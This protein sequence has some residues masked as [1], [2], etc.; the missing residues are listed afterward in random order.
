MSILNAPTR[1]MKDLGYGKGYQYAHDLENKVADMECMPD[2]LRGRR[3]YHPTDQG[4]ER[5][6]KEILD[7][8]QEK[9]RRAASKDRGPA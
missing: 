7:I 5:R 3:Y 6:I 2:A 4:M 9:R 8:I 1:L